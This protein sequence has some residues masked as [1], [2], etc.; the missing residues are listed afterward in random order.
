MTFQF[1]MQ[2]IERKID[3]AF[4]QTALQF[5]LE[6]TKVISEA[7]VFP[8]FPG[9][10]IDTGALR[11]SQIVLFPTSHLADYIWGVE[12]AL[13]VHEGVTYRNG[14]SQ[15][16]RPWTWEALKTFNW[17]AKFADNLQRLL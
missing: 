4:K 3:E 8:D 7:G 12:Y 6:M 1:S 9:D 10:I 2:E 5:D 17:E 11:S 16:G 13:Y 15:P 14:N